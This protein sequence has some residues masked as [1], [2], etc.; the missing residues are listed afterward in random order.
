M[1]RQGASCG[2]QKVSIN[3]YFVGNLVIGSLMAE[4]RGTVWNWYREALGLRMIS[5]NGI[6]LQIWEDEIRK[7]GH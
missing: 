4:S 3:A 2:Y 1:S 5:G 7:I 6:P